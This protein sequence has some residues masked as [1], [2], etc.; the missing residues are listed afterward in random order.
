MSRLGVD[1]GRRLVGVKTA[2]VLAVA[3]LAASV[4]ASTSPG[5]ENPPPKPSRPSLLP[6]SLQPLKLKGARF[7]S[8]ERVR[9]TVETSRESAT[10]RVR[11]SAS[12]S[13]VVSF[14]GV[15]ACDGLSVRATGERGSH[16][17][18]QLASTLCREP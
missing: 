18:L 17:S 8:R 15:N 3:L 11:A 1:G 7:A 13:F 4:A 6:A 10:R 9:V 12:G 5:A 16:A 14:S 2:A